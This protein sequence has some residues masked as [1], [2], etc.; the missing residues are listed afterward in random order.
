MDVSLPG[1]LESPLARVPFASEYK[2][3]VFPKKRFHLRSALA[4]VLT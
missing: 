4:H 2:I 3:V 1:S